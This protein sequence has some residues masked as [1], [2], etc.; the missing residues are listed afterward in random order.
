MNNCYIYIYTESIVTVS[1]ASRF[2]YVWKFMF[3]ILLSA[4][5]SLNDLISRT[6]RPKTKLVLWHYIRHFFSN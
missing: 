4:E 6:T 1:C 2:K 5:F 3:H